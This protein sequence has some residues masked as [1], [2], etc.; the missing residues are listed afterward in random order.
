MKEQPP[1]PFQPIFLYRIAPTFYKGSN[2][3][4]YL[5]LIRK[6]LKAACGPPVFSF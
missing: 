6:T 1:R 3:A 4:R 5:T 2:A